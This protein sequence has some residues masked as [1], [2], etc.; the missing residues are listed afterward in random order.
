M[1]NLLK[2]SIWFGRFVLGVGVLLFIQL[3]LDDIVGPVA[4]AARTQTAL[5]SAD[6]ITVVRVQGGVFVAIAMILAYCLAS[7]QRLLSGLGLLA[8][9]I[10]AVAIL[11]LVGLRLDGPGHFTVMTVK[12]EAALAVLSA[13]ALLFE[14]RRSKSLA[15]TNGRRIPSSPGPLRA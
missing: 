3:G 4:V 10:T 13:A 1:G 11:R 15:S 9:I 7:E 2:R 12:A 8:T 6:A 5:G 14:R